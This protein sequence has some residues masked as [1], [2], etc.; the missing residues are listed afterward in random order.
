[1]LLERFWKTAARVKTCADAACVQWAVS[2]RLTHSPVSTAASLSAL[3]LPLGAPPQVRTHFNHLY[4]L[5]EPDWTFASRCGRCFCGRKMV[6]RRQF[7]DVG[8]PPP[9]QVLFFEPEEEAVTDGRWMT[10]PRGAAAGAAGVKTVVLGGADG[11]AAA[12]LGAAGGVTVAPNAMQAAA[13]AGRPPGG[14]ATDEAALPPRLANPALQVNSSVMSTGAGADRDASA[15]AS[16]AGGAAV[17]SADG[18][19]AHGPA[20]SA[21]SSSSSAVGGA[22]PAGPATPLDGPLFTDVVPSLDTSTFRVAR[23]QARKLHDADVYPCQGE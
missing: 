10:S 7:R 9:R 5:R 15:A 1:V 18:A 19:G 2:P 21:V 11:I 3:C 4:N 13:A 8:P 17:A 23:K 22:G 6:R 14:A 16:A 12:A 20:A